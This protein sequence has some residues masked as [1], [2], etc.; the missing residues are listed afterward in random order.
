[1]NF[2]STVTKGSI[3]TELETKELLGEY[4]KLTGELIDN[5]EKIDRTQAD[6]ERLLQIKAQLNELNNKSYGK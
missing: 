1:M 4:K 5:I 6:W 3:K 2:Y